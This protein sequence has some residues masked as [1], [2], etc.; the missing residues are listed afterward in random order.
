MSQEKK[1]KK[2]KKSKH[3]DVD[4]HSRTMDMQ[5]AVPQQMAMMMHMRAMATRGHM[6]MRP[7]MMPSP[8]MT[9]LMPG[10]PAAVPM[11]RGARRSKPLRG[12]AFGRPPRPEAQQ[13]GNGKGGS[14]SSSSSSSSNSSSS[15]PMMKAMQQNTSQAPALALVPPIDQSVPTSAVAAQLPEMANPALDAAIPALNGTGRTMDT[16]ATD[17][18]VPVTTPAFI[19]RTPPD[20]VEE[21]PAKA[22]PAAAAAGGPATAAEAAAAVAAGAAA[23][24]SAEEEQLQ[25]PRP[26][27]KPGKISFNIQGAKDAMAAAKEQVQVEEAVAAA[28]AR[29]L[30]TR[31]AATQTVRDPERQDGEIVTIWRLRPRGMES[32]PHFPRQTRKRARETAICAAAGEEEESLPA[33]GA[34]GSSGKRAGH[35]HVERISESAERGD[36]A[37]AASPGVEDHPLETVATIEIDGAAEAPLPDASETLPAGCAGAGAAAGMDGGGATEAMDTTA[38]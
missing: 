6:M 15:S 11:G 13:Y 32:F 35:G 19:P 38:E 34:K 36:A 16:V 9:P 37:P 24:E 33:A 8:A 2:A 26:P 10:M 7:M 20:W 25:R 29:R 22:A 3:G 31:D 23:E 27:P 18:P 4:A 5:S 30:N 28:R 17:V 1:K 12:G 21:P 14:S